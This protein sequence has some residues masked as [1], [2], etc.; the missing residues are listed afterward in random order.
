MS[1]VPSAL[2]VQRSAAVPTATVD[3]ANPWL[4]L[5]SYTEENRAYFHGRDEEARELVR[6]LERKTLTILFGQ[7][8]LGKSSLLQAGVFPRLRATG[9]VPIYLRL[10]HGPEAPPLA[11]Q[12]KPAV[13]AATT[14]MGTWSH[15]GSAAPGESLW[16]YFHH[17][18]DVLRG[19]SG[20]Q[21]TP[22]LVFDQFEELFTLGAADDATRA[23]AFSFIAELADLVENRAPASFEARVDAGAVSAEAFDFARSD[24]RVLITLREDYLPHLE[25]LKASMPSLMQNRMRL[26]RLSGAQALEAVVKPSPGLVPDDVAL[27]IVAFVSGRSDPAQAE[28]EPSLLSLVCRELNYRRRAAHAEQI[29]AALLA[30][31]RETI[32]TEFYERT[33]ADQSPA[34]R[35]SSQDVD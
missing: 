34:V 35:H 7:S 13:F 14:M 31:S 16:E 4:G 21:L 9:F 8:G 20:Q 30:G 32:L 26:T 3:A 33:M 15:P 28:V 25:S 18:D 2:N 23:R 1:N 24:Y 5:V 12:I 10:D 19:G 6:R 11:E 27:A 17:R 29:D 22:V